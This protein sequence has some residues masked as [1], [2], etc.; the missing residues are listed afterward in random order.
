[1]RLDL[2]H[3]GFTCTT[4]PFASDDKLPSSGTKSGRACT[5]AFLNAVST[6]SGDSWKSFIK[7]MDESLKKKDEGSDQESVQLQLS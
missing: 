6:C 5:G 2:I 4:H 3:K 1:V 7:A